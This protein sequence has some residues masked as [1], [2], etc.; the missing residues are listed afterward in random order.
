MLRAL[1]DARNT[2]IAAMSSGVLARRIGMP[3]SCSAKKLLDRD[4]A[5]GGARDGVAGAELGPRDAGANGIDVD[6]EP[7]E[8]LRRHLGQRDD[9]SLARRISGIGCAGVTAA[10]DR[11]DVHD[12]AAAALGLELADHLAGGALQ[13]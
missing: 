7:A 2:V 4:A 6:V 1:G 3:A 13:I 5:G 8:L 12:A 9:R 10:A 11:G